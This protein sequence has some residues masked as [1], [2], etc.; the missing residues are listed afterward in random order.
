MKA[1]KE[2]NTAMRAAMQR[3]F[4]ADFETVE[5]NLKQFLFSQ[6]LA[7]RC[8]NR[9]WIS[10]SLPGNR[11]AA[12][13]DEEI[14]AK[15]LQI[16]DLCRPNSVYNFTWGR[17]HTDE[18]LEKMAKLFDVDI[19]ILGHQN[20]PSGFSRAGHNLVIIASDHN[21]GCLLMT[22]LAKSYTVDEVMDLIIPIA[23]IC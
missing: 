11:E 2:M 18:T 10:H 23:S 19:F 20:Q 1:G 7:V 4:N 6:P 17:R 16:T 14:L 12:S 15:P 22:D 21:H 8:A 13:F 3:E 5:L 9:M